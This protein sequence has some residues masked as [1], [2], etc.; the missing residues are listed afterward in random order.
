MME[1]T[2]AAPLRRSDH[3]W[4]QECSGDEPA[5]VPVEKMRWYDDRGDRDVEPAAVWLAALRAEYEAST[6]VCIL[7]Q[8]RTICKQ[9]RQRKKRHVRYV[10][11]GAFP[12]GECYRTSRARQSS[13]PKRRGRRVS[14]KP[15]NLLSFDL[16]P[17]ARCAAQRAALWLAGRNAR[18]IAQPAVFRAPA[19]ESGRRTKNSLQNNKWSGVHGISVTASVRSFQRKRSPASGHRVQNRIP[20]RGHSALPRAARGL[21]REDH[22]QRR[23]RLRRARAHG[24]EMGGWHGGA[25]NRA[26]A[27]AVRDLGARVSRAPRRTAEAIRLNQGDTHA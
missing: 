3:L 15:T 22:R 14:G 6:G 19:D 21:S 24:Q 13:M 2:S 20:P 16:P 11:H 8:E 5:A 27:G 7:D 12:A 26:Y 9:L 25:V 18:T 4:D 17:P 1:A 10:S 23:C